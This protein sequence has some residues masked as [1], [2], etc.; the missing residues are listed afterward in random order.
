MKTILLIE[1]EKLL[2]EL[3]QD[4][5]CQ[6]GFKTILAFT[7]KEGLNLIKKK[8]PDLI[9][10]DIVLPEADGLYFLQQLRKNPATASLLVVVLSNYHQAKIKKR[11]FDWG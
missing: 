5:L 6:T 8:K 4:K 2:A 9:L 7:A 11:P 3:C 10:L 1:D